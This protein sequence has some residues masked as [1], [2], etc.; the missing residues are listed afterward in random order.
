MVDQ[1]DYRKAYLDI[2]GIVA[3][4]F[5]A[6]EVTTV[7]MVRLLVHENDTLRLGLGLPL[8]SKVLKE[9]EDEY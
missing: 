8:P 3:A 9:Q 4:R 7:D 1:M 2:A 6:C 5:P